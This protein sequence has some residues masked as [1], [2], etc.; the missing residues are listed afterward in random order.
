MIKS[1]ELYN[2]LVKETLA[3]T[4]VDKTLISAQAR[5]WWRLSMGLKETVAIM[6]EKSQ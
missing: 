3:Y 6:A 5:G 2:Y 4:T 1:D